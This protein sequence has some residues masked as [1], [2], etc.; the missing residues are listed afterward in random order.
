[1]GRERACRVLRPELDCLQALKVYALALG[2]AVN[3]SLRCC[4]ELTVAR[5]LTRQA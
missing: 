2:S 5:G 4:G 3:D 1:M